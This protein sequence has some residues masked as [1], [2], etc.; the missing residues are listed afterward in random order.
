VGRTYGQANHGLANKPGEAS[1]SLLT[2]AALGTGSALALTLSLAALAA[3]GQEAAPALGEPADIAFVAALD[4]T[5]QY[6]MELLPA[7]FDPKIERHVLIA[8]HGHGSDR[9]QYV[10][11]SRGEASAAR[12]AAAAYGLVFISPDYRAKTS[13]MGPAAEADVVQIIA[14]LRRKYKVGKVFL[15]GGSMGGSAVLTFA[16]LHPELI[17][18]VS[19]QNGTANHL[20]YTHFQDAIQASF[21]GAKAQIPE[22]YKKRSAE[23]WPERFTMP[24]ALTVG[25]K[26]TSVP[27]DSVR[28]L[29]KV[30]QE[31]GRTVL[32]IDRPEVGHST[33]AADTRAALDFVMC[34]ALGLP[35]PN[36]LAI[37]PTNGLFF[38]GQRPA[39]ATAAG[40]VDLG[41]QIQVLKAGEIAAVWFF[42]AE[43]EVESTH[44]FK[45]WD[46]AGTC[47]LALNTTAETSSGWQRLALEK[48]FA[49]EAGA[50]YTVSY[51]A[52][53]HYPATAGAFA[54]P[55]VRRGLT[56]LAGVYSFDNLGQALPVK[57]HQQMSYGID[58]EYRP[59]VP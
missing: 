23:Y 19:S 12:E 49:L 5:T 14:D 21:G 56:A 26:D 39:V 34:R 38:A 17:A 51:T 42:K 46:A 16:A 6:Y 36:P 52:A 48:P 20:E 35:N 30:L 55:I 41:L 43:G 27:P 2:S 37:S 10:T 54:A 59:G 15:V 7:G 24:V 50:A 11:E 3:A 45:F 53:S 31:M 33:D 40:Q 44:T 32:L 13:W 22:E 57:T 29:A 47:R 18:G 25:G 9:H 28:R 8:L 1:M 58:L 4:G